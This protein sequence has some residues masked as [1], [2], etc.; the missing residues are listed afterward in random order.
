MICFVA[1]FGV[2]LGLGAWLPS[3]LTLPAIIV[4]NAIFSAVGDG[5]ATRAGTVVGFVWIA[6]VGAW[7]LRLSSGLLPQERRL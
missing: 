2:S 6:F 4:A 3:L 1:F 7:L 5:A